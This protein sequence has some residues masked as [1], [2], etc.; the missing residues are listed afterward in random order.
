MEIIDLNFNFEEM[1]EMIAKERAKLNMAIIKMAGLI[2]EYEDLVDK[3]EIDP[4]NMGMDNPMTIKMLKAV[5]EYTVG[6]L[7]FQKIT[8]IYI[9]SLQ[10]RINLID[11]TIASVGA[12]QRADYE[13]EKFCLETKIENCIKEKEGLESMIGE[14]G[15]DVWVDDEDLPEDEAEFEQ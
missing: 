3:K 7:N 13:K 4:D 1:E 8:N 6:S 10:A 9:Y 5:E 11:K 2:S 12:A 14:L 15:D